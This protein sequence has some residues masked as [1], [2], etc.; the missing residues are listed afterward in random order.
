MDVKKCRR[1]GH[2]YQFIRSPFCADCLEKV[3]EEYQRVRDYLEESPRATIDTIARETKV[4][5][6]ILLH[7]IREGRLTLATPQVFCERCKAAIQAGRYCEKCLG[8]LQKG[9][10]QAIDT[11][12]STRPGDKT[13]EKR[14]RDNA[15]H[16]KRPYDKDSGMH[17]QPK[18][19]N[20]DGK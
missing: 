1:C 9:L 19:R 12:G 11:A 4:S 13:E 16:I 5:R 18:R 17:V 3:D 6:P 8:Q 14:P 15:R 2:M 20:R 7:L 10:S